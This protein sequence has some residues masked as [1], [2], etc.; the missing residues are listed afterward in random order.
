MICGRARLDVRG[1][2]WRGAR[3]GCGMLMHLVLVR[4]RTMLVLRVDMVRTRV[5]MPRRRLPPGGDQGGHEQAR[6][7]ALH[8][9]SLWD[10]SRVV[11]Q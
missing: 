10:G 8:A 11:N 7:P 2:A 6:Q 5:D 3:R 1:P 4:R 9:T